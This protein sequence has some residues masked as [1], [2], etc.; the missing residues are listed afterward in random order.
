MMSTAMPCEWADHLRDPAMRVCLQVDTMVPPTAAA[1]RLAFA[2][3]HDV[4]MPLASVGATGVAAK[5]AASSNVAT[6]LTMVVSLLL[7]LMTIAPERRL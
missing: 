4:P 6:I 1:M 5:A 2:D 7:T 3:K